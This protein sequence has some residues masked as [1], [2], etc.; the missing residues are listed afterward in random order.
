MSQFSRTER[1][2]L[3]TEGDDYMTV[4]SRL[5]LENSAHS[6]ESFLVPRSEEVNNFHTVTGI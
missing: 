4:A 3:V 2:L 5:D 1:H 6:A